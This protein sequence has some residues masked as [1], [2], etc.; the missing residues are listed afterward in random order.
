MC[1]VGTKLGRNLGNKNDFFGKD[2]GKKCF[3]GK[4]LGN[5]MVF[6]ARSLTTKSVLVARTLITK[7]IYSNFKNKLLKSRAGHL[8]Y[9]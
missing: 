2:L 3:F 9:K 7:V 5:K 6:L 1:V 8:R 4:N